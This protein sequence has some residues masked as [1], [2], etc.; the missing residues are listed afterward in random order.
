MATHSPGSSTVVESAGLCARAFVNVKSASLV[1]TCCSSKLDDQFGRFKIW[2]G[3]LGV[4]AA[5]TASADYR[6][7]DEPAVK[8]VLIS[9]LARLSQKLSDLEKTAKLPMIEEEGSSIS[10]EKTKSTHPQSPPSSQASS[11]SLEL[12]SDSDSEPGSGPESARGIKSADSDYQ[13]EHHDLSDIIDIMDRLYRFSAAVRKPVSTS[14]NERVARFTEKAKDS[15]ELEDYESFVR[16]QIRRWCPDTTV[17]LVERLV[18]M[19]ISRR[20]RLLY[21]ERHQQKLNSGSHEWFDV[22]QHSDHPTPIQVTEARGPQAR[23]VTFEEPQPR[24]KD[25]K[26]VTLATSVTKASSINHVPVSVYERSIA[27]TGVTKSAIARRGGLDVPPPPRPKYGQEVKCPYC[28]RFL[29]KEELKEVRWTRHIIK[30]IDPYVCLFED[31]DNSNEGFSSVDEWLHHMQWQHTL[32]WSC[33]VAGHEAEIFNSRN[34]LERHIMEKHANQFAES[35]LPY[36]LDKSGKPSS[37]TFGA[38]ARARHAIAACKDPTKLCP[39]CPFSTED[40]ESDISA[41][42]FA[43]VNKTK[44]TFRRV[45][46]HVANHLEAIALLSL[47][48]GENIDENAITNEAQSQGEILDRDEDDLLSLTS[49]DDP[50][51]LPVSRPVTPLSKPDTSTL[52]GPWQPSTYIDLLWNEMY[53]GKHQASAPLDPTEDLV[54]RNFVRRWRNYSDDWDNASFLRFDEFE[55]HK[56][57][58]YVGEKYPKLRTENWLLARLANGITR[59]RGYVEYR[60]LLYRRSEMIERRGLHGWR[61]KIFAGLYTYMCTFAECGSVFFTDRDEWFRH[62]LDNHRIYYTCGICGDTYIQSKDALIRH[63]DLNHP[64]NGPG[65]RPQDYQLQFSILDCPCCSDWTESLEKRHIDLTKFEGTVEGSVEFKEHLASHL[66]ELAL[67]AIPFTRPENTSPDEDIPKQDHLFIS[68]SNKALAK[69]HVDV[70]SD[71][72]TT[73]DG[74]EDTISYVEDLDWDSTQIAEANDEIQPET[75]QARLEKF[76]SSR[77]SNRGYRVASPTHSPSRIPIPKQYSIKVPSSG[78]DNNAPASNVNRAAS[79]QSVP[80]TD[81]CRQCVQSSIRCDGNYPCDQCQWFEYPESCDYKNQVQ[82]Q[83]DRIP[84]IFNPDNFVDPA[85]L[86]YTMENADLKNPNQTLPSQTFKSLKRPE[87]E[88]PL[89]GLETQQISHKR[90]A[91]VQDSN[92]PFDTPSDNT[93]VYPA[94]TF[95]SSPASADPGTTVTGE[96]PSGQYDIIGD[97]A[98]KSVQTPSVKTSFGRVLH[99]LQSTLQDWQ[100]EYETLQDEISEMGK[101]QDEIIRRRHLETRLSLIGIEMQAAGKEHAD[102]IKRFESQRDTGTEKTAKER[103]ERSEQSQAEY[104]DPNKAIEAAYRLR[105]ERLVA[106][107]LKTGESSAIAEELVH[108]S[109]GD[110]NRQL[111]SCGQSTDDPPQSLNKTVETELKD[112]LAEL[113]EWQLFVSKLAGEWAEYRVR[114]EQLMKNPLDNTK[115]FIEEY[116][117]RRAD[118][119]AEIE[120]SPYSALK[121]GYKTKF[122]IQKAIWVRIRLEEQVHLLKVRSQSLPKDL[123]RKEYE[124]FFKYESAKILSGESPRPFHDE[125]LFRSLDLEASAHGPMQE[126]LVNPPHI[127]EGEVKEE[128]VIDWTEWDQFPG[129]SDEGEQERKRRYLMKKKRRNA[130]ASKRVHN[131]SAEADSSSSDSD[132]LDNVDISSQQRSR[133]SR[134]HPHP[135]I[136]EKLSPDIQGVSDTEPLVVESKSAAVRTSPKGLGSLEHGL[137]LLYTD[138]DDNNLEVVQPFAYE[139]AKSE[140]SGTN[141]RELL[142]GIRGL[143]TLERSSDEEDRLQY[144]RKEERRSRTE[145]LKRAHGPTNEGDSSFSDNDP[146]DDIDTE[147]RRLRRR[148]R[149]PVD[150]YS[151]IFQDGAYYDTQNVT[152]IE[153]P[154]TSTRAHSL[155]DKIDDIIPNTETQNE[156]NFFPHSRR[157]YRAPGMGSSIGSDYLRR[158]AHNVPEVEALGAEVE[159]STLEDLSGRV[160]HRDDDDDDDDDDDAGVLAESHA[161]VEFGDTVD[162][163]KNT[164]PGKSTEPD[165]SIRSEETLVPRAPSPADEGLKEELRRAWRRVTGGNA[166]AGDEEILAMFPNVQF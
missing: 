93:P 106:Q 151:L 41:Y 58:I 118:L 97:Q 44:D 84:G 123:R 80:R 47:P 161:T 76:D 148:I 102:I 64:E 160:Q 95:G 155:G 121:H 29:K 135:L 147:A 100:R 53:H 23:E 15:L 38:L 138:E 142:E 2:T 60:K 17:V 19:V 134:D 120:R 131:Q 14:E 101:N 140:T 18:Q 49:F 82:S 122:D 39:L 108:L 32:A 91:D 150:R 54:M 8:D 85:S 72:D 132:P 4:F 78:T 7:R 166:T 137:E 81:S 153:E 62:E 26:A 37:N 67:F 73:I 128:E 114:L 71:D 104:D 11:S 35:Q 51:D 13:C 125:D 126:A 117:K 113:Q 66:E 6:L 159:V 110:N 103:R 68:P 83:F 152:E 61:E 158:D 20:L 75:K 28:S 127:M 163:S 156:L 111:E 162:H 59:R 24:K 22:A 105:D 149:G 141:D 89:R 42:G 116:I 46:D 124:T 45:R 143:G 99:G 157:Y 40:T 87:I 133:R 130:R 77:Q 79:L 145:I 90:N 139:D 63:M 96:K 94:V 109:G 136:E 69:L 5:D 33:P 27:P 164:I 57:I 165:S 50:I 119:M 107:D 21:R 98:S 34:G 144:Y 55:L 9:I 16:W 1:G 48:V 10:E 74:P 30:D 52:I 86:A 92:K 31:C 129:K 3:S 25:Q 154:D 65:I 12:S 43:S 88:I 112:S 36:F 146:L 56:D 70:S 115:M